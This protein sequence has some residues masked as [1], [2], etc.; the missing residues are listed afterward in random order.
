MPISNHRQVNKSFHLDRTYPC[1]FCNCGQ[2]SL[3]SMMQDALSCDRCHHIFTANREE[4]NV[5]LVD[6]RIPLTW[7]WN[8]DKWQIATNKLEVDWRW[9]SILIV[10]ALLP[11]VFVGFIAYFLSFILAKKTIFYMF[12]IG[13]FLFIILNLVWLTWLFIEDTRSSQQ[14]NGLDRFY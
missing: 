1:P 5:R 2:I 8:K 4:Q 11:I 7:H 14:K 13:V 10:I 12:I 6:G 3:M 9:I